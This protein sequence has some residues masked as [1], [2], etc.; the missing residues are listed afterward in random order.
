MLLELNGCGSTAT[1]AC[2]LFCLTK[3]ENLRRRICMSLLVVNYFSNLFAAAPRRL[4]QV[5][6]NIARATYVIIISHFAPANTAM[7]RWQINQ[8]C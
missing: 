1:R 5:T 2:K 8:S 3:W 4:F 6:L 7:K